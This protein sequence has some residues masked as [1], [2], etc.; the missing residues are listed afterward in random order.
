MLAK[1]TVVAQ[2]CSSQ[3][4]NIK[5]KLDFKIAANLP[6]EGDGRGNFRETLTLGVFSK[7]STN[8]HTPPACHSSTNILVAMMISN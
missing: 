2:L 6:L 7:D 8:Q 5:T 3:V 4:G 1:H